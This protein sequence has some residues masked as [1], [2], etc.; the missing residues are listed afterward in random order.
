[1]NKPYS[2]ILVALLKGIIYN[3]NEKLWDELLSNESDIKKYFADIYL[4]VVIDKSEGFA[5]LK[6]RVSED[7]EDPYPKLIE[8][9]QLNFHV[10]LL[11]LLLRKH[12]IENDSEGESTKVVLTKNEIL[13]L[14]KPFCKESTNEANLE[15][16]IKAAIE[17]VIEEGFLRKMKTEDDQYEVSRIIKAFVNADVVKDSL[18]KLKTYAMQK[19]E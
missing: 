3:H 12:L 1:M 14:V 15:K 18:E 9:R 16:Q 6:Q 7:E 17:K 13:N 11:C 19:A 4:D 8:K 2:N 5:F 10:S